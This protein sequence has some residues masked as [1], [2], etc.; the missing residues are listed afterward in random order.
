MWTAATNI[1]VTTE[2]SLTVS[3][4]RQY[5]PICKIIKRFISKSRLKGFYLKMIIS[6]KFTW[7]FHTTYICLLVSFCPFCR[8]ATHHVSDTSWSGQQPIRPQNQQEEEG[9]SPVCLFC[10]EVLLFKSGQ[11][12]SSVC[13]RLFLWAHTHLLH[14]VGLQSYSEEL[15]L[16]SSWKV[17]GFTADDQPA[18]TF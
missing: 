17:I 15:F 1:Q 5:I 11:T 6:I 2:R 16:V 10:T 14:T 4:I 12:V 18:R 3:T 9:S 13:G 8:V 7:R